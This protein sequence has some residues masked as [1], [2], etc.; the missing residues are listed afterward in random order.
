MVRVTGRD[1]A[2]D[3]RVAAGTVGILTEPY[4]ALA[5]FDRNTYTIC[6]QN[7]FAGPGGYPTW[8]QWRSLGQDTSSSVTFAQC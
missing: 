2:G 4:S 1:S 3:W 7:L 8:S 5:L 6:S